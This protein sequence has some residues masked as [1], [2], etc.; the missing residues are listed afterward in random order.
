MP[1]HRDSRWLVVS[2]AIIVASAIEHDGNSAFASPPTDMA[3]VPADV[4]DAVAR[5]LFE[6]AIRLYHAGKIAAARQLF[7]EALE[8]SKDGPYAASSR[9]MVRRCEDKLGIEPAATAPAQASAG[10]APVAQTST[11]VTPL[12]V[13][14]PSS[15]PAVSPSGSAGTGSATSS[16]SSTTGS[17]AGAVASTTRGSATNPSATSATPSASERSAPAKRNDDV[18]LDPYEDD[19]SRSGSSSEGPLDPYSSEPAPAQPDVR[20]QRERRK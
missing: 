4:Q 20:R 9:E 6:R 5:T 15:S 8:R 16:A 18:P 11:A 12:A 17:V 14:A 13:S 7:A 19:S 3:A 1:H 2:F 10:I